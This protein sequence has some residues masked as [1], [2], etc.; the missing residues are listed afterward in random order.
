MCWIDFNHK[1][2]TLDDG[3]EIYI[4]EMPFDPTYDFLEY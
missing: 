3:M 1:K 2:V 4:I